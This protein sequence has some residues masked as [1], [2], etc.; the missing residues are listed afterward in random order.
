MLELLFGIVF[1]LVV[2]CYCGLLPV[3][4]LLYYW[5]YEFMVCLI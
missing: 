3:A 1:A 4:V 2:F 5:F